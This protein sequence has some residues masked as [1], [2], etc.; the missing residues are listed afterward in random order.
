MQLTYSQNA[1]FSL[2]FVPSNPNLLFESQN[3]H[4][5]GRWGMKNTKKKLKKYGASSPK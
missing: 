5:N 2:D 3:K 1:T 4:F